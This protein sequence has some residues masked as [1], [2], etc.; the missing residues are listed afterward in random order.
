MRLDMA[1]QEDVSASRLFSVLEFCYSKAMNGIPYISPT[2]EDFAED[3]LKGAKR[4]SPEAAKA[5]KLMI[6]AQIAK[7]SADGALTSFGGFTTIAA[8]LPANITSVIYIHL[9]MIACTAYMAGLDPHSQDVKTR[10]FMAETGLSL[11]KSLVHAGV[12]VSQRIFVNILRRIP[13][14]LIA[15]INRHVAL[16]LIAKYG[17]KRVFTIGKAIPFAGALVGGSLD[18]VQAAAIG[19]QAYNMFFKND[20]S[21]G[22]PIDIDPDT[23]CDEDIDASDDK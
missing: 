9:R 2:I 8:T 17:F 21:D 5:A 16:Q 22:S 3:Y 10:A 20:Y 13:E 14:K 6:A 11:S 23:L 12:K 18:L 15:L 19:R 7:C 4:G 1:N